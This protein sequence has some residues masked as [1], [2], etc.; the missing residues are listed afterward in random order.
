MKFDEKTG[1]YTLNKNATITLDKDVKVSQV[2]FAGTGHT[3]TVK[4]AGSTEYK[5]TYSY[6]FG[7]EN[8]IVTLFDVKTLI[9][10]DADVDITE[11]NA[12]LVT[13]KVNTRTTTLAAQRILG[14]H[15]LEVSGKS[16]V[17]IST[18]NCSERFMLNDSTMTIT[19]RDAKVVIDN[20]VSFGTQLT[21]SDGATLEINNPQATA[22]NIYPTSIENATIT[23]TGASQGNHG[24]FIFGVKGSVDDNNKTAAGV[25]KNS[26]IT[27]NGI[28]GLYNSASTAPIDA[29]G[30]TITAPI[31]RD[32]YSG[33]GN[34]AK[35][36][37]AT[38]NV[39]QIAP[40]ITNGYSTDVPTGDGKKTTKLQL[41]KV[42]FAGKTTVAEGA[43]VVLSG[44]SFVNAGAELNEKTKGSVTFTNDTD[45]ELI[46]GGTTNLS[47]DNVKLASAAKAAPTN[48]S[49]LNKNLAANVKEV[50][51]SGAKIEG[52]VV[53]LHG[54]TLKLQ[55]EVTIQNGAK[56]EVGGVING[57]VIGKD[58]AKGTFTDF[59]GNFTV[60][61]GSVVIDG[62]TFT[63][64][65]YTATSNVTKISGT[66]TGELTLTASSGSIVFEKFVVASSG[67]LTLAGNNFSVAEGGS[68]DLYGDITSAGSSIVVK[69]NNV[70]VGSFKAYSGAKIVNTT[71]TGNGN[72]D[73]SKAQGPQS[74]GE[75]ISYDKIYG[76]LENVTIVDSL[77]IKNNAV[78]TILGSFNVN[79]N[80]VLTIESG[81]E[82]IINS[83]VAS[84]I[85]DGKIIVEQG[86]KLTVKNAKSVTVSGSIESEGTVVIGDGTNTPNVTVKSN[87]YILV[88]EDADDV[89]KS[90]I[91]VKGGLTIETDASMEV[92]SAMDITSI[93]NKGTITLNGAVLSDNTTISQGADGAVVD[94]VSVTGAKKLEITDEGLV[95]AKDKEVLNTSANV[96][97]FTPG[98]RIVKG[99]NVAE[100]VTSKTKD[101]V[102]TYTN[103]FLI[104]GAV[105]AAKEDASAD[106]DYGVD[107]TLT[108]GKSAKVT[109]TLDL[110]KKVVL[111]TS[112]KLSVSGTITATADGS[113][114]NATDKSISVSGLI[115]TKTKINNENTNVNAAKY[116]AKVSNVEYNYYTTLAK[117][118]EAGAQSITVLGTVTIS[119][120]MEIPTGTT[121]T[122]KDTLTIGS[123]DSR[124]VVLTVKDGA[125]L[126]ERNA[127]VYGTLVFDNK[128]NNRLADID[129]D[130]AVIGDVSS[131]YTNIYTALNQASAGQT[132]TITKNGPVVL[133]TSI[134][135][136]EGVILDVPV[137]KSLELA[138][139][140]TVTVEGT[141]R[142]ADAVATSENVDFADK[143]SVSEGTAAIQL[144][145]KGVFMVMNDAPTFEK[146]QISG[147]YYQMTDDVGAYYYV[148]P[149]EVAAG[150][151]DKVAEGRIEL[152]GKIVAGDVKFA[153]TD[154]Q[155][156]D[157]RGSNVEMTAASITLEKATF[158]LYASNFTGS[159]VSGDS[160]VTA[161]KV[162]F[163]RGTTEFSTDDAFTV[164]ATLSSEED[165]SLEISKGIVAV[166]SVIGKV[167]VA[168]GAT[169]VAPKYIA[170]MD[171]ADYDYVVSEA[172]VHGNLVVDNDRKLA[173]GVLTVYGSV[174]VADATIDGKAAGDLD[175]GMILI[176]IGFSDI[177]K[178][179][180]GATATITGEVG[181]AYMAFVREGSSVSEAT[182]KIL[183]EESTEYYVEGSKWITVYHIDGTNMLISGINKAPVQNARFDGKW[184][185]ADKQSTTEKYIGEVDKVYADIKYDVYR[186]Q[187]TADAG[188][189][190]IAVDGNLLQYYAGNYYTLDVKA[191]EH[192]ITYT[193]K[194]GYSG[195]AKLTVNGSAAQGMKFTASGTDFVDDD[196]ADNG[197]VV[198][199][200]QLSGVEKSGYVDPTPVTPSEDKDDG[201]TITDYLLIVLVVLIVIM[202]VI[203]AMRLM[204][205]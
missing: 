69:S 164:E 48:E 110:G 143:A 192:T 8:S 162:A 108:A 193:L 31:L 165:A 65:A 53:V 150:V 41:N 66:L 105:T 149:I 98:D 107:I 71:I 20:A 100:S 67:K 75:D 196:S 153:G 195:T 23:V 116:V 44:K 13:Q 93:V 14:S 99:L 155:T 17:T 141:L 109:E 152:C 16:V 7:T 127:V 156:V 204:R 185:D 73:L 121:V 202:A 163:I 62:T 145:G 35:L 29:Q 138:K 60:K 18:P 186:L 102:V 180:T 28:V 173:V 117:A 12:K 43:E 97:S 88:K 85:V 128:K 24:L 55:N 63:G 64:G 184:L 169:L 58:S 68:F 92:R 9:V 133:K 151:A 170:S 154:S 46:V 140:V 86:A 91:T 125:V 199:K 2:R 95:F 1:V 187:L 42:V 104:S 132:V 76:Q 70:K 114:I 33:S 56:V 3:L 200:L 135:I 198:I 49:D 25:L 171:A 167:T 134:T 11:E 147:A 112:G 119:E 183:G 172:I 36:S 4:S 39:G 205:S 129:S 166:Y 96:L 74:V 83:S 148:A 80:V 21:M 189:E 30:T 124:D 47:G 137:S 144:S 22:A 106:S 59:T 103:A 115:Q 178:D 201:L 94:I 159:I 101:G 111:I 61:A 19:G 113:S 89:N 188:I 38:L 131:K 146:Y 27:T 179:A 161:K 157:V 82:L 194:N 50:T 26:V 181:V 90:S 120:S 34:D 190:N 176:G 51:Y 15:G 77:N 177:D 160:V 142:T 87:G 54:T 79:E 78:V 37:G 123:E 197:F 126:K 136:K 81:S 122:V 45:N 174:T 32:I 168:D 40:A 10:Q 175:V 6:D 5:L 72:I 158:V 191:G 182:V 57:V 84:M 139:G 203:V 52:D 118:V 130:V